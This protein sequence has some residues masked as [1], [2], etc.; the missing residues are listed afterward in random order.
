MIVERLV[1]RRGTPAVIWLDNGANFIGAE[2][3]LQESIEKWNVVNIAAE[4]THKGIKWTFNP[5]SAQH[6]GWHR[7]DRRFHFQQVF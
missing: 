6:Q 3:E 7:A 4:L 5:P 2:K 1:S